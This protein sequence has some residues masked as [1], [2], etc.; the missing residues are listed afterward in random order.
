MTWGLLWQATQASQQSQCYSAV[1][2]HTSYKAIKKQKRL[3]FRGLGNQPHL[4][5]HFVDRIK[6]TNS[7]FS[8]YRPKSNIVLLVEIRNRQNFAA[9]FKDKIDVLPNL[10]NFITILLVTPI[11]TY[12]ARA[13]FSPKNNK[14]ARN[15]KP[16]PPWW[17]PECTSAKIER[18]EAEKRYNKDMSTENLLAY[19]EINTR[20]KRLLRQKKRNG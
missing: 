6:H 18:K 7:F 1:S 4:F 16:F 2:K 17:D 20:T 5:N 13:C 15:R 14:N 9:L 8:L 11:I 19:L 12:S 3:P 10:N